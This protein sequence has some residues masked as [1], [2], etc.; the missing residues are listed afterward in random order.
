MSS[1]CSQN[2]WSPRGSQNL[3]VTAHCTHYFFEQTAA[4][5]WVLDFSQKTKEKEKKK[6]S[7]ACMLKLEKIMQK[8]WPIKKKK[9]TTIQWFL[10]YFLVI[11]RRAKTVLSEMLP[12][13]S[14]YLGTGGLRILWWS[15]S[16]LWSGAR[17]KREADLALRVGPRSRMQSWSWSDP[18]GN[19]TTRILY[20]STA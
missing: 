2:S 9:S 17:E 10:K 11:H 8:V 12:W 6:K 20:C 5:I 15:L 3:K 19:E 4:V 7:P 18:E 13:G 14:G 1:I 16:V